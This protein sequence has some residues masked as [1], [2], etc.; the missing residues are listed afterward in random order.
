MTALP[1]RPARRPI[2]A[3]GATGAALGVLAGL[4]ELTIG[5]SIRS[6][7]GDKHDTSGSGWQRSC[8]R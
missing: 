4:L 6:W 2:A 5:P 7:L 3:V 1:R 8:S